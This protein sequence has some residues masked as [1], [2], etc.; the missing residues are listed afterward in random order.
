MLLAEATAS[1]DPAAE[2]AIQRAVDELVLGKTVV[3]I[4]H[5]LRTVQ[6]A[7]QIVVLDRGRIA[8]RGS[9]DELLVADGLY[10]RLWRLQN[11]QPDN[12]QPLE[13]TE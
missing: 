4:A 6:R 9:H 12:S 7:S 10:A 13:V 5:R 8:E 3:V 11:R 1:V 2:S